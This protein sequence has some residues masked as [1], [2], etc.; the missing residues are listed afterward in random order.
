[1][2]TAGHR[3]WQLSHGYNL[4]APQTVNVDTMKSWGLQSQKVS[5]KF[6]RN[7]AA[8]LYL[9]SIEVTVDVH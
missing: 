2:Q 5:K 4:F 7:Y 6:L 1:M 8:S 3:N 9:M